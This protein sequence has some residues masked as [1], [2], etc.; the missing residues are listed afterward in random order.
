MNQLLSVQG[1]IQ[2]A[3]QPALQQHLSELIQNPKQA[4]FY[5]QRAQELVTKHQGA[6]L[7]TYEHLTT[8]SKPVRT[9]INIPLD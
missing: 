2:V 7:A 8:F 1:I 9:V 4:K 3:D 5:G 6:S